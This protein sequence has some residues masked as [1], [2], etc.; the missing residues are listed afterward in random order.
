[1]QAA[2]APAE[3]YP[4]YWPEGRPRTPAAWRA[5]ARFTATFAR[6]RDELFAE[7]VRMKGKLPVLSTNI[8]L[9]KDGLPYAGQREPDD[10]GI[11]LY[12]TLRAKGVDRQLCFAC[13]RW[14]RVTDNVWAVCKTIDSLRGIARWGTGDM[15]EAAFSGFQAIAAPPTTKP[16]STVFGLPAD[17]SDFVVEERYRR[18]AMA[19]HPDRGG[20][21]DQMAAVNAAYEQFKQERGIR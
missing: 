5:A 9:R 16:W 18:M 12:F 2:S 14:R 3:A 6:A 13:D 19:H 21:A 1:M 7:I 8:P 17:A 15:I 4:L 20:D 10:P 11:A